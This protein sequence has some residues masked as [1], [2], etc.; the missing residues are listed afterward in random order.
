MHENG[1]SLKRLIR[2]KSCVRCWRD[3]HRTSIRKINSDV[4]CAGTTD[5]SY[6]RVFSDAPKQITLDHIRHN[7][8]KQGSLVVHVRST[9]VNRDDHYLQ[10]VQGS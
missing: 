2:R 9:F 8:S 1:K 7:S 3:K 5:S 4:A 6:K 10:G